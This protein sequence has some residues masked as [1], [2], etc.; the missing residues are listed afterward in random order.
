MG[1][2]QSVPVRE[3]EG[4]TYVPPDKK[5]EFK[6]SSKQGAGQ[7]QYVI[8]PNIEAV[9]MEGRGLV[10]G[11]RGPAARR[12]LRPWQRSRGWSAA[13]GSAC[14]MCCAVARSRRRVARYRRRRA[15]HCSCASGSRQSF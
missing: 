10:Q 8:N 11:E 6:E 5:K 2:F 12:A 14:A 1:C 7:P 4:E 9:G 3:Y 15:G 13:A